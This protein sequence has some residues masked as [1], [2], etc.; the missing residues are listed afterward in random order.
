MSEIKVSVIVPCYKVEKYLGRCMDI[1]VN[2]TLKEIEI[3]LVDDGSPDNC[4]KMCDDYARQDARV[5]VIHQQNRGLGYARNSGLEIA[6]GDYV[7]FCDSDDFVERNMYASL[8]EEAVASNADVVFSNF[9]TETRKGT[10]KVNREVSERR[11]WS[12]KEVEAFM[13][14]MVAS[15]PHEKIERKYQMSVWHSIYR[16]SIIMESSLRFYSERK[17]LSE[18]FPFQMDFLLRSQKV[19]FLPQAFYHYCLNETSLTHSF[20]VDKFER[21]QTLYD[22][23]ANQLKN[24]DGSQKRLDRFYIG[25]VRYRIKE[26]ME[27]EILHKKKL[28]TTMMNNPFWAILCNRFPF[29]WLPLHARIVYYLTIRKNRCLLMAYMK[30]Y[31]MIK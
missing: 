15:A 9:Y 24:V 5:K 4:P 3:I 10:W 17:V 20:N 7:A 12:G 29:S 26:L 18:D 8:Y 19:V 30:V 11:E 27:S 1:L 13:L 2:Q 14:D 22:I 16:R 21:I 28:L 23:M 25:Y 6:I 31:L